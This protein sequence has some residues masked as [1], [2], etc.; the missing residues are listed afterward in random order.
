MIL[1]RV[2]PALRGELTRWLIEPHHGVFIGHVNA[3]VRDRLWEKCCKSS[4]SNAGVIQLWSTNTE[5]R[6]ALRM[7]GVTQREIVELEGLQLV[8]QPT[9]SESFRKKEVRIKRPQ[10]TGESEK[11]S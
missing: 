2:T 5:Q 1:E 4:G 3:M 8:R 7:S 10:N 6:F 11:N 9:Q